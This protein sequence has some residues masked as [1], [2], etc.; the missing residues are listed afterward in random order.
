MRSRLVPAVLLASAIAPATVLADEPGKGRD[1]K[2][3]PTLAALRQEVEPVRVEDVG[4]GGR[5]VHEQAGVVDVQ[6]L[7]LLPQHLGAG[8]DQGHQDSSP[9]SRW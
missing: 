2:A 5:R 1:A 4:T 9:A 3:Y 7:R 6:V 8:D